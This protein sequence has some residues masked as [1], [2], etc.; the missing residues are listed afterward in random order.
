M[1]H[2]PPAT[3]VFE[4]L[5]DTLLNAFTKIKKPDERFIEMKDTIDKLEDNLNTVERLYSRISKR[6]TGMYFYNMNLY[7]VLIWV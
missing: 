1:Q 6:Q 3:S 5:S 4:S 7:K 2:V